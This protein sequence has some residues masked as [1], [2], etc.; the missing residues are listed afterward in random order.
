MKKTST[1]QL[2]GSD[3]WLRGPRGKEETW[4]D[5]NLPYYAVCWQALTVQREPLGEP[6]EQSYSGYRPETALRKARWDMRIRYGREA[7]FSLLSMT[8]LPPGEGAR[9]ITDAIVSISEQYNAEPKSRR[10]HIVDHKSDQ[11]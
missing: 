9:R 1:A 10:L 5:E 3:N 2:R 11:Q 4:T 7:I 6:Y 8:R